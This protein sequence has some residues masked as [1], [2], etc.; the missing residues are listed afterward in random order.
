MGGY[1]SGRGGISPPRMCR[2][3]R[4]WARKPRP[5]RASR[6]VIKRIG[7]SRLAD[8]RR[9]GRGRVG[10]MPLPV[11]AHLAE[12]IGT[13]LELLAE[14]AQDGGLVAVAVV[15]KGAGDVIGPFPLGA[16]IN[17]VV[18]RQHGAEAFE[19]LGIDSGPEQGEVADV[20]MN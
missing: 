15:L 19:G 13:Q 18:A 7:R 20:A 16:V 11:G 10:A 17:E 12:A 3:L 9:L 8:G 2:R 5:Y 1:G 4:F 14:P 6:V